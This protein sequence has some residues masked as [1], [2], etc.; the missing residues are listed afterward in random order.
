MKLLIVCSQYPPRRSPE[1]THTLL[2]CEQLA[3]RRVE[4]DLLTS[5]LLPGFPAAKGFRLHARMNHGAGVS[6]QT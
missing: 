3:A 5:E 6:F 1:S 4:V 2:L